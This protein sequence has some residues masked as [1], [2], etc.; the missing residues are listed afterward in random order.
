M[1]GMTQRQREDFASK[2][3]RVGGRARAKALSA[4][5][6]AEIAKAAAEARWAKKS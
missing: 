1:S 4:E 3:G 6:R 2:G 5:R